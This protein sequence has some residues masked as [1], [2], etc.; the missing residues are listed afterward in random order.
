MLMKSIEMNIRM[1]QNPMGVSLT[2][3]VLLAASWTFMP[4]L[5][6]FGTFFLLLV[7]VICNYVAYNRLF[8]KSLYGEEAGVYAALPLSGRDIVLGKVFAMMLWETAAWPIFLLGIIGSYLYSALGLIR[9]GID[10]LLTE[11]VYRGVSPL[12]IG[13]LIGVSTVALAFYSFLSG[14][15]MLWFRFALKKF[16]PKLSKKVKGFFNVLLA[17]LVLG[18]IRLG[19]EY[20]VQ[21]IWNLGVALFLILAAVHILLGIAAWKMY[22]ASV[23]YFET[24]Y[25]PM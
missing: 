19:T 12:T 5:G 15:Y 2:F 20:F 4:L 9:M 7:P 11:L 24:G 21:G 14:V 3:F 10:S 1:I 6:L 16:T 22:R 23:A 8:N 18:I 17:C 25:S 13:L